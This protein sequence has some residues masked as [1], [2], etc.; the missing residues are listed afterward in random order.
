M[1]GTCCSVMLC[2]ATKTRCW[3]L[4]QLQG[5]GSATSTRFS[6]FLLKFFSEAQQKKVLLAK[7]KSDMT[8]IFLFSPYF[9]FPFHPG[10]K[11]CD[12]RKNASKKKMTAS[13]FVVTHAVVTSHVGHACWGH[14]HKKKTFFPSTEMAKCDRRPKADRDSWSH[15]TVSFPAAIHGGCASEAT[16]PAE[17]PNVSSDDAMPAFLRGAPADCHRAWTAY[18][19]AAQVC[20]VGAWR[21]HRNVLGVHHPS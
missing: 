7:T 4:F 21:T 13:H 12:H 16:Q 9:F 20:C 1:P 6:A 10:T 8:E 19:T 18:M 17:A 11:K 5:W 3:P 14:D 2:C 15:P